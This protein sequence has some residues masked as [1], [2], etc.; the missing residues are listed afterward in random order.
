MRKEISTLKKSLENTFELNRYNNYI[1]IVFFKNNWTWKRN[2][3]K[4]KICKSIRRRKII[5]INY[6][7]RV[8]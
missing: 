8:K 2:C 1:Y 7:W 5:F 4:L 6:Q 3:I